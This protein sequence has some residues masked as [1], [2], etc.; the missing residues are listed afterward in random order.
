[1]F[2]LTAPRPV[3]F[4]GSTESAPL[5]VARVPDLGVIG[6]LFK[7]E[8]RQLHFDASGALL[9]LAG[10]GVRRLD[11]RT[12]A[13][14][15]RWL[16]DLDI[17]AVHPCGDRLWVITGGA[18][19]LAA[20]AGELGAPF[21]EIAQE[22]HYHATAAGTRLAIACER[23][24]VLLDAATGTTR[25]FLLDEA[26]YAT[27]WAP[28]RPNRAMLSPSGRHVGVTVNHGRY[29]VVWDADTGASLLARDHTEA[30][31]ILDDARIVHVDHGSG[32]IVGIVDGASSRLP[33]DAHFEDAQVRGDRLLVADPRGGFSL[34]E[35]GTLARIAELDAFAERYGRGSSRV[36][37]ALSD[38]HVATYSVIS[39]VLRSTEIGGVTVESS[40]WIGGGSA[41]S[42]GQG[43]RR[44]GVFREWGNG[45]LDCV[46]LDAA[47]LIEVRGHH[48][49][50][51]D[52]AITGDGRKVVVPCGSILRARTVHIGEFGGAE[53][54][55]S[56]PIK[57]CVHEIVSHGDD[58]YAVATY[59]LRGSGYV[60]LHQAGVARAIAKV[61]R[62]KEAPWR[63]AVGHGSE[64]LLV[65]WESAT[66]LYDIRKRPKPGE[67][68]DV[69]AGAVALGPPGFLAFHTGP[70]QLHL[71]TPG[72]PKRVLTLPPRKGHGSTRL[73]FSRDG[74]LLFVGARDGMLEVRRS[75]DGTLLRELPLHAGS[76]V[77]LQCCGEALWTMGEDG[78]VHVLGL[79][80][81]SSVQ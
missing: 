53:S 65:A 55:A 47:H 11:P 54:T 25:E 16:P 58:A 74:A 36:C 10:R 44:V 17:L 63:I 2:D 81:A 43:G 3:H 62:D 4:E 45:R 70:D 66:I 80:N 15:G 50:I 5:Q 23:G 22:R 73:A 8:I 68:W 27:L 67:I 19:F 56:H 1:M 71:R 51:T 31:A 77:A 38:T 75:D 33:A 76:H 32:S 46:D 30:S 78:L 26:W 48:E 12:L 64:E 21:A 35:V 20:F 18:I 57:S 24:A 29:T 13:E 49:D 52:S 41:L 61:T 42:L 72:S 14:T 28:Q 39:G 6:T 9:V 40:D 7:G 60:G 69:G 37:A 34:Y 59:T 79:A